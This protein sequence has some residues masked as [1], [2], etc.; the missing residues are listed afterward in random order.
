ML[1]PN[2]GSPFARWA[3]R[4]N[5]PRAALPLTYVLAL[6]PKLAY[7][8]LKGMPEVTNDARLYVTLAENLWRN[9]EFAL[10][11]GHP[12]ISDLCAYPLFLAPLV[13]LSGG[14]LIVIPLAQIAMAALLAPMA[15]WLVRRLAGLPAAWLAAGFCAT[16]L[17]M[18]YFP[19]RCLTESPTAFVMFC[20]LLASDRWLRAGDSRPARGWAA[21]VGALYGIL[22]LTRVIALPMILVTLA[23]VAL[24]GRGR[25]RGRMVDVAV[26]VGVFLL[27]LFPWFARNR[28]VAADPAAQRLTRIVPVFA[29]YCAE[30][31]IQGDTLVQAR[32][33]T[34]QRLAELKRDGQSLRLPVAPWT[35]RYLRHCLQRLTIMLGV[36]PA[37]F[38]ESYPPSG[39]W[40]NH[41]WHW[42]LF[43]C[44]LIGLYVSVRRD[45]PAALHAFAVRT[46]LLLLY[47][48]IHGIP[49]YQ[50][51]PFQG[52]CLIAG[53][54]AAEVLRFLKSRGRPVSPF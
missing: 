10:Q 47:A 6:V 45:D 36:H 37:V 27:V 32:E 21:L 26:A 11:P 33:R 38:P 35:P 4:L 34:R 28:M 2:D 44:V 50:C 53:I 40:I 18:I 25:F 1:F 12:Y 19:T 24:R 23:V 22:A 46:S 8:A 13:G 5:R 43:A 7:L 30:Y 51:V 17:G 14:R 3:D 52:W 54:G 9:G 31:V 49:R 48:L 29:G 41:V 39:R 16:H 20:I 15:W 42:L